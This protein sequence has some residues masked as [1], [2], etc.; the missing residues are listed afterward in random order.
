MAATAP[1][2]PRP[3]RA[4][5]TEPARRRALERAPRRRARARGR[6]RPRVAGGVLWIFLVAALLAGIVALNVGALR[7][8]LE[9]QRLEQRKERLLAE[10]AA[11]AS[12]ISSLAAAGRIEEVARQNLGLVPPTETTY[13]R[14]GR[15]S[16]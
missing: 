7:F 10:N 12:E 16:R 6:A 15:R 2:Q 5:T 13:V 1:A 3:P 8:N 4:P 11:T 9:R 14:V